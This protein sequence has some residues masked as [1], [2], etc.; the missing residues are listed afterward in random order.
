HTG[1]SGT[2]PD[3][4]DKDIPHLD[5]V[6]AIHLQI[7]RPTGLLWTKHHRPITPVIRL[8]AGLLTSQ[9]YRN[10]FPRRSPAPDMNGHTPLK[11]H[12]IVHQTGNPH[13]AQ[14]RLYKK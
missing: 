11:D 2:N 1:F 6:D 12:T 13:L 8:T 9:L 3:I 7:K 14:N 4:P 10:L 5:M